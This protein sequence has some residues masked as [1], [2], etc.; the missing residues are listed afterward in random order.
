LVDPEK[1]FY[2]LMH[3]LAEEG[4]IS[5]C[6]E[7]THAQV[8]FDLTRDFILERKAFGKPIGAFKNSRFKM[9]EMRTSLDV[10]QTFIAQCVL[11]HNQGEL[12]AVLAAE[13]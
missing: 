3:H 8:A 1:D 2:N 7:V 9:T 4:L 13:A 12:D 11:L 6:N 10:L 5:V